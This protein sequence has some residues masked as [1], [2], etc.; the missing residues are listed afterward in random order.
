M[1]IQSE[2]KKKKNFSIDSSAAMQLPCECQL[3]QFSHTEKQ[4]L[5][6]QSA[7]KNTSLLPARTEAALR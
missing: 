2:Q 5:G 7:L 3:F 6:N 4:F 1:F